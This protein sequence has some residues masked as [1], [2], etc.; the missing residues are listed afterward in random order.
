MM[1]ADHP[2]ESAAWGDDNDIDFDEGLCLLVLSHLNTASLQY[3][4]LHISSTST[5]T[6]YLITMISKSKN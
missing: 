4:S 2:A 1:A 3:G 6:Y 5:T